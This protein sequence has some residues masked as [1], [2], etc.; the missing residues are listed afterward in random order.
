MDKLVDK[1]G[2]Q[3]ATS[4]C[5]IT[6][7]LLRKLF[8]KRLGTGLVVGLVLLLPFVVDKVA[9]GDV[10]IDDDRGGQLYKVAV[11]HYKNGRWQLASEEFQAFLEKH[12]DH[13]FAANGRFFAG[14]ALVQERAFT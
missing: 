2:A 10:L 6:T 1:K 4:S 11:D 3:V 12:P 8:N 13:S 14:E 7:G 5:K 9:R